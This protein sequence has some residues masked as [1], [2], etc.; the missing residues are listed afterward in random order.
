MLFEIKVSAV[1]LQRY[2]FNF[3]PL[4]SLFNYFKPLTFLFDQDDNDDDND[5]DD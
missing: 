4:K 2:F 5:N 1:N 3:S